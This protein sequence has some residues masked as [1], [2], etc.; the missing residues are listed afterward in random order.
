MRDTW[1]RLG[2]SW[3]I[4]AL[5]TIAAGVAAYVVSDSRPPVYE[6][7]ALVQVVS[8]RQASG[9]FVTGE[10]LLHLTNVFARV[11]R[12][13]EVAEQA[14]RE[15]DR[16]VEAFDDIEISSDPEVEVLRITARDASPTRAA[17]RSNAY[18][19]A[20]IAV[21]E[22]QQ[23][24]QRDVDVDRLEARIASVQMTTTTLRNATEPPP[25]PLLEAYQTR[26][27][28]RLA[29]SSDSARLLEPA[30]VPSD[31]SSPVPMRDAV[32]AAIALLGLGLLALYARTATSDR[33][34]TA[35]EVSATLDIPSLG[36]LPRGRSAKGVEEEVFRTIRTSLDFGLRAA[37]QPVVLVT[38][39]QAGAGKTHVVAGLAKSFAADGRRVV[40]IDSDVRRPTLHER[41][42]IPLEPGLGD[43]LA[44]D[45]VGVAELQVSEVTLASAARRGGDLDVVAAGSGVPDPAEALS[46]ARMER[47]VRALRSSYDVVLLDSPPLLGVADALVLSRYAGGLVLVVDRR[48]DRRTTTRRAV[49]MLR[50]IDAPI[51]GFVFNGAPSAGRVY[52]GYGNRGSLRP[53]APPPLR[54]ASE[55]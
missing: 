33:F 30:P 39:A 38:S 13:S 24:A 16:P 22:Q 20:F 23:E 54:A 53:T 12:T 4:L 32:L 18:A 36:E 42:G 26:L 46:S 34:A 37:S 1:A 28:D 9:D 55:R 52:G 25:S 35:E 17:A 51:V 14:A 44:G 47:A 3:W 48:R 8:G 10:E 43:L 2:R 50:S 19:R 31:P 21:L 7:S 45:R 15:T 40:A 41:L 27:A 49:E 5:A 11:A 6:S 29:R